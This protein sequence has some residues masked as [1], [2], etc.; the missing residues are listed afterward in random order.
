M[1]GRYLVH[2]GDIQ[3]TP[4]FECL[5]VE[6]WN[7]VEIVEW[8]VRNKWAD[9]I[10]ESENQT[11]VE[12]MIRWIRTKHMMK[13]DLVG[14]MKIGVEILVVCYVTDR[15]DIVRVCNKCKSS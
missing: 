7:I 2:K 13:L 5:G 3:Y 11:S 4:I 15:S 8:E 10:E 1:E 6:S 9:L 14:L 12:F